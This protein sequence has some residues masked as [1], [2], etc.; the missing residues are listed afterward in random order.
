MTE[1]YNFDA[2]I[3]RRGSGSAKWDTFPEEYLPLFVA[4][5][6][7]AAPPPVLAALRQ[8]LEHPVFGYPAPPEA[9][10]ETIM[11]WF[12]RVY[13]VSVEKSWLMLLPGI[14]PALAVFSHATPGKVLIPVPNYSMLLSAPKRAG[15]EAVL[16]PM[17]SDAGRYVLDFAA[18]ERDAPAEGL[19]YFCNP[20]NPVGRVYDDGELAGLADFAARSGL[21]VVADEIH[22]EIVFDRPHIPFFTV[23]NGA[24]NSV[25]LYAPGKICN[26]PGLPG[27]FAVVPDPALRKRLRALSYGFHFTGVLNAAACRAAFSP[28]CDGWKKD[29]VRYLRGNRDYLETEIRRRF[30]KVIFPR[31][32]GTYLQWLDFRPYG[33]SDPKTWLF[34]RAKLALTDGAPFG[35]PGFVRLNFACPRANLTEALNRLE[36][37]GREDGFIGKII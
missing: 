15:K 22:C 30:P 12:G 4:D 33:L 21:V 20:H 16:T 18:L 13:G 17:R 9:L 5:A 31:T 32:E 1:D 2:F 28:E 14:V 34:E 23:K 3:D 8:R 26:I 37:Q 6:D 27:A 24:E 36:R 25:C 7:F 29:L 10:L 19:L 35:G 11:E